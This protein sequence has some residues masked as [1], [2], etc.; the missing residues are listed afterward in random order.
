MSKLR[1][2]GKTVVV[3]GAG[4]GLGH[5]H[6]VMFAARGANVVVNDLAGADQ[7]AEGISATGAQAVADGHDISTPEGAA[8]LARTAFD[9]FGSVDVLV[10]NA[11]VGRFAPFAEEKQADF[12]LIMKVNV[13]GIYHVTRAFWPHFVARGQGRV[14]NTTSPAG[15]L[16]NAGQAA[17]SMSKG[18]IYALTRSLAVEGA[19]HNISVSAIAPG[20]FTDMAAQSLTGHDATLARLREEMPSELV[21]PVV[22]YLAHETSPASGIT[23]DAGGGRVGAFF[24]GSTLGIVDRAL[25]PEVVAARWDEII[26]RTGYEVLPDGNSLIALRRPAKD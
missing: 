16:G 19:E 26:D 1:F 2:D 15:M 8:G 23:L 4:R 10:N 5:A 6:T 22:L 12:D 3:T 14:V 24:T 17:Y 18:A 21:S 9:A 7:A 13:A 25:T 11:G 20:A